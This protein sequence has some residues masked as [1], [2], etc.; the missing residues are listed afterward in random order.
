LFVFLVALAFLFLATM[1]KNTS[2]SQNNT[3]SVTSTPTASVST[4][5]NPYVKYMTFI[6]SWN[7]SWKNTTYG[8]MGTITMTSSVAGST[9]TIT[10]DV[11]GN[12]FGAGDPPPMTM[13]V[14]FSK[15]QP[16]FNIPSSSILGQATAQTFD[17][18]TGNFT[19]TTKPTVS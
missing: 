4:T 16:A 7:G 8:S 1:P 17:P 9:A 14:D 2:N 13:T 11:N 6:G 18:A 10:T 19:I 3:G 5:P 15:D 12:V